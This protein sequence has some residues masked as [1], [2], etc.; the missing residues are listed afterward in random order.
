MRLLDTASFFSLH[1]L[2]SLCTGDWVERK[3]GLH[4]THE[5]KQ[6]K[7]FCIMKHNRLLQNTHKNINL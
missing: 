4:T 7:H 1:N 2:H 6:T 5:N 3:T